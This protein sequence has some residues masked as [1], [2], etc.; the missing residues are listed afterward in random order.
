M[1]LNTPKVNINAL[2]IGYYSDK[3]FLRTQ[4]ILMKDNYD[5]KVHYQYFPR[6]DCVVCGIPQVLNIFEKCIGYYKDREKAWKYFRV[7]QNVDVYNCSKHDILGFYDLNEALNKLWVSKLNEVEVFAI[8]E[9]SKVKNMEPVIGVI[10]NPKYF[11]HLE[12]ATLGVLAQQSAVATSVRSVVDSLN[13]NQS[14]LFFPA[15]FRHYNSQAQ[16]GYAA[17]VGGSKLMSTDANN[18]YWG[19]GD[20]I[21]TIPHIIIAAYGGNTAL[22]ALKFDEMID[23]NVDRTI[24]VDWDN[25]VIKTTLEVVLAMY[26]NRVSKRRNYFDLI[27]ECKSLKKSSIILLEHQLRDMAHH[28]PEIIG[29]GK[30]K[31]YGVRFDTSGSLVDKTFTFESY[32]GVCAELVKKARITFDE[33]GLKDLKI[34]VS[35]GFD[36]EKIDKFQELKVPVDMFGIGSSIVNKFTVDFTADA[37][38]LDGKDNSKVGRKLMNWDRLTPVTFT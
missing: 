32:K 3:Y 9:G 11:A 34:I 18:A 12:T 16:D 8:N 13:P 21:G 26:V 1:S 15:R 37:V 36:N 22:A 27:N 30:G 31:I 7:M 4:E 20:G 25:D 2:R 29:K 10:G 14:M 35:G 19:Y 28:I 24:L 38:T 33:L 6:K 5:H 17:T 23:P